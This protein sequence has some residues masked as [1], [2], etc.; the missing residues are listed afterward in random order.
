MTAGVFVAAG[1]FLWQSGSNGRELA[2][3]CGGMLAVDEVR[4]VLGQDK[5]DVSTESGEGIDTCEVHGDG[6][7][8]VSVTIVDT[9][10]VGDDRSRFLLPQ[11]PDPSDHA[12]PVPIG[13]GWSGLFGADATDDGEGTT[14]LLLTC[15]ADATGG[16]AAQDDSGASN[17][18]GLAVTVES[19]LV[20]TTVDNPAN[21]PDFV[22]VATGTA[23]KAAKA[24]HCAT[25]LGRQVRTVGLPVTEEEFEPLT[26]TSGTCA[27]IRPNADVTTA[28][29]TAR[30]GAARET[31]LLGGDGLGEHRYALEAYYGAYAAEL[32]AGV[33]EERPDGDIPG[34]TAS[35]QIDPKNGAY[36]G[37]A[38]CPAEG[39]QGI[40]TL[41]R[42]N[43]QLGPSTPKERIYM[44]AA[45]R[46]FAERSARGHGCSAVATP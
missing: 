7:G 45:L 23:A 37:S 41:R 2:G 21:R 24:H 11:V 6:Q 27:G 22:R 4:A 5:L 16:S 25:R 33:R 35:G 39:E 43:N 28:Q 38:H 17:V 40:F 34:E 42:A 12:L 18:K 32:K 20:A 26:H 9:T 3:A 30:D 46:A 19:D 13:H 8:T 10:D 29:E 31:C 15:G 36:W 44:K 1:G 14:T